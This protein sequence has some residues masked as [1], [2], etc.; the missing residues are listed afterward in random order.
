MK[1]NFIRTTQEHVAEE[2]RRNGFTELK[3][4][5]SFFVFVNDGKMNFSDKDKKEMI[6]SDLLSV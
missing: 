2:L 3:K 4:D 6:Y 5:G 1:S